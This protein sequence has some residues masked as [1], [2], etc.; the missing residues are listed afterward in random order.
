MYNFYAFLGR[1]KY[2]KRWSLMHNISEEDIMQHSMQ[3][4]L[5]AHALAIINNKI[6]EG[7]A[8]VERTVLYAL[9][10]ESA[11]VLTGDLP[12]PIKYFNKEI[13]NSYKDIEGQ[14]CQKLLSMLPPEFENELAR[15]LVPDETSIEYTLV[16]CADKLSAYTKCL[17]ELK[18]GNN[19]FSKAKN[20]ILDD[21]KSKNIDEVNYFLDNFVKGFT[22]SLDEL[23]GL[24]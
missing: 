9:Y 6:F 18:S 7:N 17:E 16:K 23:D 15:Y 21:L 11:E 2:I 4:A 1:M 5:F 12:T 24:I 3:V 13:N 8:N 10:H 19:E 20:T 22:L 14:A